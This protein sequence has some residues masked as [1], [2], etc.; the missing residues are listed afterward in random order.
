[1]LINERV[2]DALRNVNATGPQLHTYSFFFFDLVV[3]VVVHH[4]HRRG[5]WMTGVRLV[6]SFQGHND[7]RA[8]Y[9]S[10]I[11]RYTRNDST[12]L[13][14]RNVSK[15]I[16]LNRHHWH[17]V[18]HASNRYWFLFPHREQELASVRPFDRGVTFNGFHRNLVPA[19]VHGF[20]HD[21]ASDEILYRVSWRGR[22]RS[23]RPIEASLM[24]TFSPAMVV[25]FYEDL[26]SRNRLL[27]LHRR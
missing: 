27:N 26:V 5:R 4:F 25:E 10:T 9:R 12:Y 19:R 2:H 7:T 15:L 8:A 13:Y 14:R 22:S 17:H 16:V 6:R 21:V 3:V 1:M 11:E 24:R 20:M 23:P 18:A